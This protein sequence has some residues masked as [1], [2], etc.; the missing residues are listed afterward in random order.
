[1]AKNDF[2]KA[3]EKLDSIKARVS[4]AESQVEEAQIQ[5]QDTSLRSP[6]DGVVV[7]RYLERGSL[8]APGTRAFTLADLT[9]VKAVFGVPDYLL[10]EIK[11]GASLP[12]VVEALNNLT[13]QGI[14]TAI[15]PSAD[16]RSRVFEVELTI[17]NPGIQLKDGMIATV[18]LT[19]ATSE[20]KVPLAPINSVARLPGVAGGHMV[21][22]VETVGGKKFARGRAVKIGT[23]Y[24]NKVAVLEG[25]AVGE[26]I[27]TLGATIVHDGSEVKVIH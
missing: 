5:L 20:S 9:S 17:P 7:A 18:R 4:G 19:S 15:S 11:Q 16:Q 10:K 26:L 21:Y 2:D 3:K 6:M 14:V 24:E 1:M 12:I 27:I 8:V 22:V 23:I 13:A 25:L